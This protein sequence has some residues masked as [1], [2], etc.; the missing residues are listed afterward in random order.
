MAVTQSAVQQAYTKVMEDLGNLKE[1]RRNKIKLTT[2]E[3]LQEMTIEQ[4]SISLNRYRSNV[5]ENS[6]LH[7]HIFSL[8]EALGETFDNIEEDTLSE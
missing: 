4:L 5:Q 7:P 2:D 1:K 3:V 8:F 6:Q